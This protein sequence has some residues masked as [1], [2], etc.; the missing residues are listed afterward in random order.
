MNKLL[1]TNQEKQRARI[2]ILINE[3]G[4]RATDRAEIKK[5][6]RI[7]STSLQVNLKT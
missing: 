4:D 6:M 3:K 7:P 2:K 1:S 5:I